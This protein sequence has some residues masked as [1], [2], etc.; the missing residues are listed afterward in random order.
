MTIR[1]GKSTREATDGLRPVA[2]PVTCG[3]GHEGS[4]IILD[5]KGPHLMGF[6]TS[7]KR[8]V[9]NFKATEFGASAAPT[10]A[11]VA[12]FIAIFMHREIRDRGTVEAVAAGI[13]V[14]SL[15]E[16]NRL[17]IMSHESAAKKGMTSH[18][19]FPNEGLVKA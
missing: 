11:D 12:P 6:C 3:C 14:R 19:S 7:C 17:R 9:R 8:F 15:D 13:T 18:I 10:V 5:R 2:T 16:L 4:E 1:V